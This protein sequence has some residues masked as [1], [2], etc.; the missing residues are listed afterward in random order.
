MENNALAPFENIDNAIDF[1][2]KDI[3]KVKP[4]WYQADML[5]DRAPRKMYRSG[6]RIGTTLTLLIEA[7]WF[8]F[9]DNA[10]AIPCS[11]AVLWITPGY[12]SVRWVFHKTRELLDAASIE[13]GDS[14]GDFPQI[15]I[16]NGGFITSVSDI[17]LKTLNRYCMSYALPGCTREYEAITADYIVVDNA[18]WLPRETINAAITM[19]DYAPNDRAIRIGTSLCEPVHD[20][21][22]FALLQE[23]FDDPRWSVHHYPATVI[24]GF[25]KEWQSTRE[26]LSE[27][28]WKREILAEF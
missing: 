26:C 28:G 10:R 16:E 3:L 6:R 18:A 27:V 15:D 20:E 11:G 5:R 22:T 17:S 19:Y 7:L 21:P 23:L 8:M 25:E 13:Y 12:Q 4:R 14:D 24:P 9:N 1:A 2:E